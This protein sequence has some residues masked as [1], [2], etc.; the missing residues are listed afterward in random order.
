MAKITRNTVTD[1]RWNKNRLRVSVKINCNALKQSLSESCLKW[2][3]IYLQ[4]D[5]ETTDKATIFAD[6]VVWRRKRRSMD[7]AQDHC[8]DSFSVSDWHINSIVLR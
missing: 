4:R 2:R 6:V 8:V 7:N 1:S 3:L 5:S